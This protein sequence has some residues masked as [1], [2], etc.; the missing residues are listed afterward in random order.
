MNFVTGLHCVECGTPHEADVPQTTCSKCRRPLAVDYDL[1]K[2]RAAA[3]RDAVERRR[4]SMWRYREVLPLDL[5]RKPVSLGEGG[6]PLLELPRLG[7]S[8]GLNLW[9]KDEATNPTGSFKARGMSAAVTMAREFGARAVAAPS[10][11]NAG[12][13]LAAYGAR[14]GLPVHLAMPRDV[15]IANRLESEACGATVELIDGTIADCGQWIGSRASGERWVDV[16][17]LKEPYRVEG[18]KTMG[19]ELAEQLGWELPDVILYPT[20]GGTGLVGM[21]K[22]FTEMRELGWLDSRGDSPR[23]VAVQAAGCAP[24][25]RA[26]ERDADRAIVPEAPTTCAAGLRVPSP[27]GDRWMLDV[28]RRSEGTALAIEDAELVDATVR[29]S[30][31]EGIFSAPEAGALVAACVR[32]RK[33]GWLDPKARVVLFLTGSGLK[34]FEVWRRAFRA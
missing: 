1:D 8:L 30:R 24:V 33:S 22:A 19:Y 13:A 4:G 16:S 12:G 10:A 29:L 3:T 25:V 6:T 27:I 26:F 21:D 15:P 11:G 7:R 17:T 9:A 14:A 23:M 2:I 5:D 34:Y 20:G 32:L 28:L 31:E 18:K